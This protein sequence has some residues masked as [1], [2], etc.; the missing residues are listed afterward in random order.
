MDQEQ[1]F[2]GIDVSKKRLDVATRPAMTHFQVDNDDQGIATLSQRLA[3][4]KP[5]LILLEASGGFETLAAASLRQAGLPAQIINPRQ[6]REFARST[7]TLAKTDKIDA[8][9][10]AHFAQLLQPPRDPG[11]RLSNRSWPPS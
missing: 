3:E 10:L 2:I 7:N 1:V 6:V 9:V 11:Q 8:A 4:L 5:Q